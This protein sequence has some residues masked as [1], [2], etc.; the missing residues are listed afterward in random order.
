[1]NKKGF[2]GPA[3]FVFLGIAALMTLAAAELAP[4][5]R[6]RKAVEVCMEQSGDTQA[7]CEAAVS[8]LSEAQVMNVIRDDDMTQ[9]NKGYVGHR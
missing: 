9:G 2:A 7:Q 3:L 4:Q 5:H 1:M 8:N 6:I